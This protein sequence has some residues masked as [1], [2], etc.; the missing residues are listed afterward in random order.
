MKA[1][2]YLLQYSNAQKEIK[3]L[4]NT[5]TRIEAG[6]GGG[7]IVYSG[8]PHG[9]NI[10]HPTETAAINITT[11]KE[12]LKKAIDE[13]T[14]TMIDVHNT[15][16]CLDDMMQKNVLHARY[17]DTKK[18]GDPRGWEAIGKELGYHPD[19][20]RKIHVKALEAVQHLLDE[21]EKD[22]R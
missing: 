15:I 20:A 5:L 8:M 18:S 13:A 1:K 14:L 22:N 4:E 9:T 19:H 6:I 21:I 11:A 3:R 7:A 2:D 10:S 12:R 17:I 16:E